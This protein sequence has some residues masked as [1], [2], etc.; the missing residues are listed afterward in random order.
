MLVVVQEIAG[1]LRK[2]H[3][4]TPKNHIIPTTTNVVYLYIKLVELLFLKH[5]FVF[6]IYLFYEHFTIFF[7]VLSVGVFVLQKE[8]KQHKGLLR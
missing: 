3:S 4:A 7:I 2:A 1:K 6:L 5:H 8:C